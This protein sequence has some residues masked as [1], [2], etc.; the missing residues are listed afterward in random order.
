[1]KRASSSHETQC[2]LSRTSITA[3]DSAFLL[4]TESDSEDMTHVDHRRNLSRQ[5]STEHE[6]QKDIILQAGRTIDMQPVARGYGA[7]LDLAELTNRQ[8]AHWYEVY[9]QELSWLDFNWRVLHQALDDRTP[10]LERLRFLAITTSNLDEFFRKRVGGLKRQQAAG[11]ENLILPG[12]SPDYQIERISAV[13]RQMIDAQSTCFADEL[14][15]ALEVVGVKLVDY[16]NLS[17]EAIDYLRT[18]YINELYPILTPLAVDSGH[19]FPFISNLSLNLAILLQDPISRE[20][21][22]ARI[23][24]PPNRPRWIQLK[25]T[26]HFV[27]LEQVIIHNLDVLFPGMEVEA[28]FPFRVTRNA[29]I[30][31]KEDEADDLL[32]MISEELRE[33]RFASVVRLEYADTMPEQ[34]VRLLQNELQLDQRDIYPVKG[35]LGLNDLHLIANVSLPELKYEP[36][37]PLTPPRLMGI[38]SKVRPSEIFT[39]IQQGSLLVYHPYQSFTASTLQFIEAA[40]RDPQVMAIKQTLY[41]TDDDSPV[42]GALIGAAERG[43][44]VAVLVEVKARFDEEQNIGWALA[45][46]NAGCHVTYGLVGLKT[47]AKLSL[48]VRE[49]EQLKIY[50]HIGTGNYNAQTAGLYTDFGI[51]GC[52]P[53]IAKDVVDL[54]NYLTGYSRQKIYRK[55]L[56]APVNMRQRF[57][58]LIE[59]EIAN[60]KAGRPAH[61]IVQM[62]GLDDTILVERL[63]D[64]SQAGV[65]C[66]LIVRGNCRIRAGLPG[67]SENIRVISVIGRFLEHPRLYYFENGGD[68]R[69]YMGSA[70]WMSRNLS[71]RV[72]AA[73]PV[74]TRQLQATIKKVLDTL[75]ADQRLAWDMQPD[76]SYKQR[77]PDADSAS[78]LAQGTHHLMMDYISMMT[79]QFQSSINSVNGDG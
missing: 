25:D 16:D 31:R 21:S 30:A 56:V 74:E 9:N 29:D 33:R 78:D 62:N 46:E 19:P 27:P 47:H 41:R 53:E 52:E 73:V 71:A 77:M 68:P 26:F 66:D 3:P 8:L 15:P 65:A 72:E 45:L 20:T 60:A 49:E 57:V 40:A 61:I 64:A 70:D 59:T 39:Q 11:L 1:M 55:L 79:R 13:V 54:F 28:A 51:L 23:K 76:G 67:I 24:V 7:D 48:V 34:L 17:T 2:D 6:D 50:Y 12:W 58:E 14:L 22:F 38:N 4:E 75:I 5:A 37:T 42:I 18:Y 32:E 63:Y 44:Q 69:Y 10:L 43:K 36:W 35:L